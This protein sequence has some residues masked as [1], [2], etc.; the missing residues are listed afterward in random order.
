MSI[1]TYMVIRHKQLKCNISPKHLIH[2]YLTI[3]T[4]LYKY[5][6]YIA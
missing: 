5:F 4:L 3:F 2:K 1:V 6:I